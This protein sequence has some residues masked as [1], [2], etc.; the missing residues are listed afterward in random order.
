MGGAY[1]EAKKREMED[2]AKK[3]R[4]WEK[5]NPKEAKKRKEEFEEGM[6]LHYAMQNMKTRP[7]E[8]EDLEGFDTYG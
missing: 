2:R 5:K 4:E 6:A 3:E 1:I 7:F 8:I